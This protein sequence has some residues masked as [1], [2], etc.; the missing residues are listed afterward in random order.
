[1][2][3][4]YWVSMWC[5]LFGTDP[6]QGRA[7]LQMDFSPP[8][9]SSQA[10]GAYIFPYLTDEQRLSLK[11]AYVQFYTAQKNMSLP[12][13]QQ[14]SLVPDTAPVTANLQG[15]LPAIKAMP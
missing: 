1:M 11:M 14:W 2:Q 3:I 12:L 13:A 8:A 10:A 15:I 4:G 9:I 5:A 7:C 6:A